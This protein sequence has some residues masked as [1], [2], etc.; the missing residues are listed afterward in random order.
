MPCPVNVTQR[1]VMFKKV[2]VFGLG[3]LGGSICRGL[4]KIKA[5]IRIAAF[6]RNPGKLE[7]ALRDRVVDEAGGLDGM[8]LAGVEL[9]VVSMPVE[10]SID[11]I[12]RILSSP[13]LDP[14]AI[15]IDVGSVKE[16]IVRSVERLGRSDQFI[17]CHPMAGSEKMGYEFSRE[18]LFNGSSVIVTPH[19]RN[20]ESDVLA[21]R[22]FWEA[23]KA[24]TVVISPE[25]HDLIMA[26]TS[27]LPHMVASSLVRVF[28]QF[29]QE[30]PGDFGAFIGKGFLDATR[31]S[32]G[33][34][35]MWRDIVALN[36]ENILA[37]LDRMIEELGILRDVVSGAEAEAKPLHDYFSRAKS[38]RDGMK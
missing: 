9:A 4:K 6:G 24:L 28:H 37:A 15:I 27:H 34:P 38:I 13:E 11:V 35:D 12:G 25:E 30:R 31:I 20:R 16:R 2:A 18:D 32:S 23:L 17:G 29:K 1:D 21:V 36:R 8:S 7:P 26:Y 10:S 14:G 22:R 33:S 3:L 19:A 5:D